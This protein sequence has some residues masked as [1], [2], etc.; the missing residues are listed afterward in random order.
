MPGGEVHVKLF[1][2]ND[3]RHVCHVGCLAVTDAHDRMIREAGA[4]MIQRHY[5][6]Q[7][8]EIWNGDE[9]QAIAAALKS[10]WGRA[11]FECD[12]VVVNG[13]ETIHHGNGNH[14]LAFLGAAQRLGKRTLLINSLLEDLNAFHDVIRNLDYLVVREPRSAAE[15]RRLGRDACIAPDSI[16]AAAFLEQASADFGGQVVIGDAHP[17]RADILEVL[18]RLKRDHPSWDL[19]HEDRKL[20]WPHAVANLKTASIYI[21]GR[22]HGVY[23]AGLAGIPFVPLPSNSH[24]IEALIEW[25]G[26]DIP[27]CSSLDQVREAIRLAPFKRDEFARFHHF[28]TR[29]RPL[30]RLPPIDLPLRRERPSL[31][32][33]AYWAWATFKNHWLR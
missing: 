16:V 15:A 9:N 11:I 30:P 13:E 26:C 21:T 20:D 12:A 31:Q 22:H 1:W 6:G 7:G 25:S 10:R 28:L 3:T 32:L 4:V 17:S 24:K 18:D 19:H 2:A 8:K 5:V 23:L 33:R 27:V 14:L 29:N